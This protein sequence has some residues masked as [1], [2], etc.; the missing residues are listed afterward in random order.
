MYTKCKHLP[1]D[2][3]Q[4]AQST[5]T[6]LEQIFLLSLWYTVYK[7]CKPATLKVSVPSTLGIFYA[8]KPRMPLNQGNLNTSW[9]MWKQ[10]TK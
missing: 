5:R 9:N 7:V 6:Y 3:P 1:W 4:M 8:K 2:F 10:S